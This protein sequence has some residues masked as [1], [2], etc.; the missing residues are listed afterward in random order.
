MLVVT[1]GDSYNFRIACYNCLFAAI[2]VY[3]KQ[4]IKEL[5]RMSEIGQVKLSD[6]DPLCKLIFSRFLILLF[7]FRYLIKD[8]FHCISDLPGLMLIGDS[9]F[10][11]QV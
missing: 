2:T 7:I 8:L 3:K 4:K 6:N 5:Q 9:Y 11:K 1:V 10:I